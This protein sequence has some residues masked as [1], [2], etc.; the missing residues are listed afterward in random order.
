M[1]VTLSQFRQNVQD[2]LQTDLG[3]PFVGGKIE[4]PV[5]N[6]DLGCCWAA[7]KREVPEHV[8]DEQLELRVRVFVRYEQPIDPEVP[9]DTSP[10]E[11]LADRIQLSLKDKQTSL[12]VWF[13]RVTDVEIDPDRQ[14]LEVGV[15]GLQRNQFAT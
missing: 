8:D 11:Q 5:G 6:S 13:L 12:G 3:I 4:G 14:A 10:L 15:Y 7:G 2:E 9:I 1:S